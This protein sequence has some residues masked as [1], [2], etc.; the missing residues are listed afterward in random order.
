MNVPHPRRETAL[1]DAPGTPGLGHAN[2]TGL[3]AS[4]GSVPLSQV[5]KGNCI[6]GLFIGYIESYGVSEKDLG[7][8]GHGT[9]DQI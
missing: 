7:H 4:Q 2:R 5:K 1:F 8:L 6:F 9:P 3:N